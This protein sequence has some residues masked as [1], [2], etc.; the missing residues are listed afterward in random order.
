MILSAPI[1]SQEGTSSRLIPEVEGLGGVSDRRLIVYIRLGVGQSRI[2]E[3]VAALGKT[4]PQVE[5]VVQVKIRPLVDTGPPQD[6]C[7]DPSKK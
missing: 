4:S 5:R 7:E 6:V 1:A 3:I 2:D